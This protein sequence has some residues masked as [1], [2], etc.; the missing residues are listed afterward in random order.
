[1]TK[2]TILKWFGA[3]DSDTPSILATFTREVGGAEDAKK[4]K[5]GKGAVPAESTDCIV[6]TLCD[7][8]GLLEPGE[9]K[10][11]ITGAAFTQPEVSDGETQTVDDAQKNT[12]QALALQDSESKFNFLC[13]LSSPMIVKPPGPPEPALQPAELIPTRPPP[14]KP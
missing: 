11:A 5:G 13:V 1:M 3:L 14:A 12:D 10:V 6:T 2:Y 7:F 9:D 4:G 8:G